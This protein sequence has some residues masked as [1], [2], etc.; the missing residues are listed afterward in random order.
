MKYWALHC[1][2]KAWDSIKEISEHGDGTWLINKQDEKDIQIGDKFALWISG[3]DAGVYAFGEITDSPKMLKEDEKITNAH[4][5]L[6]LL[7]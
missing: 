7:A 6:N 5:L 3:K 4:I 1:N 2:L